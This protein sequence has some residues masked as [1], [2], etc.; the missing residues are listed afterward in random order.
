MIAQQVC[1]TRM[2]SGSSERSALLHQLFNL[3]DQGGRVARVPSLHRPILTNKKLQ[4]RLHQLISHVAANCAAFQS[5]C[6][7]PLTLPAKFQEM[8]PVSPDAT[9]RY[10]NTGLA[11]LPLTLTL[12]ISN[13]VKPRA[14]ANSLISGLV[15]RLLEAKLVAGEGHD[16]KGVTELSVQFSQIPCNS[17]PS[18]LL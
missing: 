16:Y 12:S 8:R 13:F 10:S 15:P 2:Y 9:L 14:P 5:G 1:P 18:P 4:W 6:S 7:K 11:S 17:R 3:G